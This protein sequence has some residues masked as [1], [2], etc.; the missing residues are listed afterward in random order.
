MIQFRRLVGIPKRTSLGV[1]REIGPRTQST[2]RF[3]GKFL[4]G[5]HISLMSPDVP[6]SLSWCSIAFSM[7]L[8]CGAGAGPFVLSSDSW[9]F[10]WSGRWRIDAERACAAPIA[11]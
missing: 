11:A 6:N 2:G 4:R 3:P 7:G 8:L 9:R 5:R 10:S 1:R